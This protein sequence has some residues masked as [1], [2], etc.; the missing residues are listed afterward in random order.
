M[1]SPLTKVSQGHSRIVKPQREGNYKSVNNFYY[2]L[3]ILCRTYLELQTSKLEN[4][5]D[6]IVISIVATECKIEKVLVDQGSSPNKLRLP[7]SGLQDCPTHLDQF[8]RRTNKNY[9]RY[10]VGSKT[11]PIKFMVVNT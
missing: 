10:E 8:Q 6:P 3:A 9:V 1:S 2:E 4:L 5:D 11:I 7:E